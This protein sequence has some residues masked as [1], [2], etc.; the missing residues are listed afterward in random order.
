MAAYG[1]WGLFPIYFHALEPTTPIE[2]L[3][4]RIL[5]SLLAVIAVLAWRHD[6]SW[7]RPLVRARRQLGQ[8]AAAAVLIAINWLVYVWA[9]EQGRVL[10]AS[11]GYF[12]NPLVTV[13][14]G[15]VILGERL[16]RLQLVAVGLGAVSV[17]V[18]A[19]AYGS[20]PFISVTLAFSFAGYGFIK[21]TVHLG[22]LHSLTAETAV[23]VPVATAAL[24]WVGRNEGLKFA[25]DGRLSV[26]LAAAGVVTAF[27]LLLFAAS[28]K[29]IP[30]TLLGLLQYITPS[31][32]FIAAVAI[33]D[34]EMSP[35][36]WVGF[37]IIWIAL[38]VLSTD[39]FRQMRTGPL[40]VTT[41]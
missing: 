8:V 10:E 35:D 9:V 16:S 41:G 30:L 19:V 12:I 6:W 3:A 1:L 24:V 39:A 4:H 20:F 23:L 31:M 7:I 38:M 13:A 37:G 25:N 34:E 36:R 33:F 21:K 5:W 40:E 32:Q 28:A 22:P 2:I 15:V 27:P 11:L 14:L 18:L 26:L 29:R 17:L